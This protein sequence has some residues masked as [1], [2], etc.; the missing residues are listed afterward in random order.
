MCFSCFE[1]CVDECVFRDNF[2]MDFLYD[3]C[4]VPKRLATQLLSIYIFIYSIMLSEALRTIKEWNV[5]MVWPEKKIN[6]TGKLHNTQL[7]LTFCFLPFKSDCHYHICA[8]LNLIFFLHRF[9]LILPLPARPSVEASL[10]IP[11]QCREIIFFLTFRREVNG[12]P[13]LNK[14]CTL[15]TKA[16]KSRQK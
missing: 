15:I 7:S 3:I 14:V 8:K 6:S 12:A 11:K 13:R 9:V 4:V 2:T 10:R 16:D 5:E 1:S